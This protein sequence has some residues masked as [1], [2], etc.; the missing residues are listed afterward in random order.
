M[1]RCVDNSYLVSVLSFGDRDMPT[2]PQVFPEKQL[3][4]LGRKET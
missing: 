4:Q 3:L 1:L 2:C